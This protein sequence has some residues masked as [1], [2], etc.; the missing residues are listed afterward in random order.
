[1]QRKFLLYVIFLIGTSVIGNAQSNFNWGPEVGFS[2]CGL[3][4]TTSE[5]RIFDVTTT[6]Y[7]P[8]K[9][10]LFGFTSQLDIK[11]HF[12][13][14]VGLR[15]LS[16]SEKLEWIR[17]GRMFVSDD[18]MANY[19]TTNTTEQLYQKISL[20]L[21]FGFQFHIGNIATNL[22][23]GYNQN[24][25][26]NGSYIETSITDSQ[27]DAYDFQNTT[28]QNPLTVGYPV[29]HFNS[30]INTGI[31]FTYKNSIV[32][33]ADANFGGYLSFAEP[34]PYYFCSISFGG[35]QNSDYTLSV[36]YLF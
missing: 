6:S 22:F 34:S 14:N 8:G 1:M 16:T 15:Y 31:S 10:V 13:I 2:F 12:N 3:K 30:Q 33:K 27:V 23:V 17:T 25:I 29:N 35:M 26:L 5:T 32:L 11:K 36:S 19:V 24:Y 28:S 9:S 20:P 4:Q 21:S 7:I 18:E